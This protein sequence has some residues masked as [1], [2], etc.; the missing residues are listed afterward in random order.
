MLY[1][2]RNSLLSLR[3]ISHIRTHII[4][5]ALDWSRDSK[6]TARA[7]FPISPPPLS[8]YID[9]IFAILFCAPDS[10][11]LRALHFDHQ[12]D[13]VVLRLGAVEQFAYELYF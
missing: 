5:V 4:L 9:Y 13:G 8:F 10:I 12:V 3:L 1:R 11:D 7:A 6:I 2:V